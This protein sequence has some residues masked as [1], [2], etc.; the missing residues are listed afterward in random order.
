MDLK[1]LEKS[2]SPWLRVSTWYTKHPKDEQR[3]HHALHATFAEHGYSIA[4]EEFFEAMRNVIVERYPG[5]ELYRATDI[6][7]YAR[8]AE[9]IG[10]YL[11]D[12]QLPVMQQ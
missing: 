1:A 4:F 9:I 10:Y 5:H 3:F 7:R 2:L 8:R 12:V 6:E 11:F